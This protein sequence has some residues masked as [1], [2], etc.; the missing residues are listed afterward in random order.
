MF[1]PGDSR[2]LDEFTRDEL[3]V[4]GREF[5]L[6]GQ[7]MDRAGMPHVI[8]AY[9]RVVMGEIAIAEWMGASPVYTKRMQQLLRFGK[10]DV[11]TIF[12]GMQ[13]DIGAPPE[14][15]DF[16]YTVIDEN[17]GEFWLDHCGALMDVEPMGAEYVTT[18]CHAIED[19]T[20]DATATATSPYAQVRPI[21]RPP[22]IPEGR[23]PHCHWTVEINEQFDPLPYPELAKRVG[24]TSAA[25]LP[26]PELDANSVD[27]SAG[28]ADYSCPLDPDLQLEQFSRAS[29][30]ALVN[31]FCVQSHLLVISLLAAIEDRFGTEAAVNIG[32]K[33]FIGSAGLTAERLH[34]A[35][36]SGDAISS[37]GDRAAAAG[38]GAGAGAQAGPAA[39]LDAIAQVLEVHSAFHPRSYVDFGVSYSANSDSGTEQLLLR[40]GPC[41]A[42]QESGRE[43]WIT[44]L[45]DGHDQALQA[46]VQAVNPFARCT[47]VTP[48]AGDL[49][50]W[51]VVIGDTEA[52]ESNEVALTRFS[53]GAEFEFTSTPVTLSTRTS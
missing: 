8:S 26:I 42:T 16:R 12:K 37:E 40:L 18:M 11:E 15:M 27:S 49:A 29:L 6:A 2:S 35:F 21:H 52:D 30:L 33:Q 41:L 13:F 51:Q 43:S 10:G 24:L 28:W 53:T 4:L 31:E 19:P 34:R 20:F 50:A 3:A 25:S 9:D 22:R 45:A 23:S 7:L 39:G 44:L 47:P 14:F 5:L 36:A 1:D 17:H 38:A 46:I 48:T 32:A